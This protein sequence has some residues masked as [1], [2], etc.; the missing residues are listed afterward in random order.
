MK[1]ILLPAL[2]CLALIPACAKKRTSV[3]TPAP[4]PVASVNPPAPP[5]APEP[6]EEADAGAPEAES[7]TIVMDNCE[8]TLPEVGWEKVS[9]DGLTAIVS[10]INPD[11]KNRIMVTSA[12]VSKKQAELVLQ[13]TRGA[14]EAGFTIISTKTV[15]SNGI[16]F[17]LLALQKKAEDDTIQV[18]SWIGV[19]NGTL[20]GL[21]CGGLKSASDQ[22]AICSSV[23]KS[24]KLN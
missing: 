2:L 9:P 14:K 8:F 10:L 17:T 5:P 20:Y 13:E 19:K 3:V 1:N 22:N 7:L 21:R 6:S 16:N 24:L 23:F 15:K 4:A 12:P 18:W 11:K